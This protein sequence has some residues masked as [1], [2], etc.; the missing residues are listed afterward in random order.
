MSH[1]GTENQFLQHRRPLL[2]K[3]TMWE[4][5]LSDIILRPKTRQFGLSNTVRARIRLWQVGEAWQEGRGEQ[6]E[7]VCTRVYRQ[8]SFAFER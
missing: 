6:K 4:Q 3:F 1:V 5:N 8:R 2:I 7:R